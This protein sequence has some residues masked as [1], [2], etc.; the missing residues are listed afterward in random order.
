MSSAHHSCRE[1]LWVQRDT[2]VVVRAKIFHRR[3]LQI[4][5]RQ[6]RDHLVSIRNVGERPPALIER[7]NLREPVA[8]LLDRR[9]ARAQ[10]GLFDF[11]QILRSGSESLQTVYLH[12][13]GSSE[14]FEPFRRRAKPDGEPVRRERIPVRSRTYTDAIRPAQVFSQRLSELDI[15]KLAER[16]QVVAVLPAILERT[17][18]NES[19]PRLWL[20][21]FLNDALH[22]ARRR[23][24]SRIPPF[25]LA[26]CRGKRAEPFRDERLDR[27]GL[28][29]PDEDERES[30]RVR[31]S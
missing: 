16:A 25:L 12:E 3:A 28:E 20:S 5:D 10:C 13:S 26:P 31:K 8:V 7:L 23:T 4:V 6:R 22:H 1:I 19:S 14:I 29:I 11:V 9:L 24:N 2:N 27:I 17:G 15:E 18:E 21:S 30:T